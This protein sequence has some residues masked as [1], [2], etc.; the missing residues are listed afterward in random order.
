[1]R[2]DA[3]VALVL[4]VVGAVLCAGVAI[5]ERQYHQEHP[6]ATGESGVDTV[7]GV[8]AALGLLGVAVLSVVLGRRS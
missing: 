1:M 3:V 6:Y 8:G 5:R 4:A 2:P 7:L